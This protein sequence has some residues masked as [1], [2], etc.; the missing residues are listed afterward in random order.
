MN[1]ISGQSYISTIIL[2]D[3]DTTHYVKDS[4]ARAAITVIEGKEST[5]D[6]KQNKITS[7]GILKG[8]GSGNISSA[9]AG[10]DYLAPVTAV[11]DDTSKSYVTKVTQT[12]TGQISVTKGNLPNATTT[13][14]GITKLGASGGA[15]VYGA[16]ST[17]ESNAKAYADGLIAGLGSY[18]TLKGV[19]NTEAEIKAITSAKKGEVWIN[20]ADNSE[21]VCIE[22][23]SVATPSAWE[24]IG[25]N[26]DLTPYLK[27]EEA[28]D[29]AY[30]DSATGTYTPSGDIEIN[31]YTPAGTLSMNNYTPAGA[32]ST[33]TGTSN[34]TPAGTVSTPTVTVTMNTATVNSITNVGTLPTHSEDSFTPAT[35][36]GSVTNET[37]SFSFDGGSYTQG[38]F[39][40]GT[41]P[42]KGSNQTVATTVKSATATQPTFT[43]TGAE[44]KFTGTASKPTGSFNG[45]AATLTG[46][47]TGT[48]GSVT[49]S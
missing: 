31:S 20:R 37:L 7:T 43:G 27:K 9:T 26:I 4:E 41:L 2:P 42:T 47:F 13:T 10:T 32:I 45:T 5:W 6:N 24:K 49:V 29:L 34:Y 33:G 28:G 44:L 22:T 38:T 12:T 1:D 46:T 30:K 21:W 15:D 40:Q 19:K 48:Q 35:W 11:T 25:Y 17:A 14:A 36:S 18:L 8:N 16:A 39:T 3:S 23:I